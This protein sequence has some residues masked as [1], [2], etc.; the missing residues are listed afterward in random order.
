MEN[1][2][3]TTYSVN[4][5]VEKAESNRHDKATLVFNNIIETKGELTS[6]WLV[7]IEKSWLVSKLKS[8]SKI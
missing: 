8:G 4:Q 7:P 5:I 6:N 1:N 2:S 3:I